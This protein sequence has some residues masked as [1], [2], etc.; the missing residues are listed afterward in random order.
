MFSSSCCAWLCL[1][2]CSC[3]AEG[4]GR[5]PQG[6]CSC[7]GAPR[8]ERAERLRESSVAACDRVSLDPRLTHCTCDCAAHT[9]TRHAPMRSLLASERRE[10]PLRRAATPATCSRPAPRSLLLLLLRVSCRGT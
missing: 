9:H 7:K 3:W 8:E 4:G 5:E 10:A 1:L 2:L 6:W